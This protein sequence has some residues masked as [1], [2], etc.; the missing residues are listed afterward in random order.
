M[1][2]DKLSERIEV[3]GN[4]EGGGVVEGF[5]EFV[6]VEEDVGG[7]VDV[8]IGVFGFVVFFEDFR[9]DFIVYFDEL[10]DRVFGDFRVGGGVVY[11]GFEV[12]IGFMEDGVV[13]VG[14][15]MFGVE[16]GLKVVVNVFFVVVF[17]DGVFYL[18][19]LVEDFLSSEFGLC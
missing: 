16:G 2:L 3:M 4:I 12:G 13:I 7:G 8:G 14:Y 15:D 5:V 10:E 11:E 17:G 9:S 18:E 1:I 6:V 19:D